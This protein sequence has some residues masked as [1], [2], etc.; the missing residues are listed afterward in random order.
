MNRHIW[1]VFTYE[2]RRNIRRK[3]FLFA[4]FGIPLIAFVIVFG[5]RVVS[6][7]NA[8]NQPAD[9]TDGVAVESDG[10]EFDGIQRA[11][12]VDLS[13]EFADP[14]ELGDILV[15][16]DDEAAANAAMLSGEI[17]G[18]YLIPA[19]YLE[20]GDVTLVIPRLSLNLVSSGPVE[21]LI[22]NHLARDVQDEDLFNRLLSPSD[23][24]E[25]NL[26]RDASGRTQTNFGT[27]FAV[28]YVFA[29]A[30]MMSVF[31]TNGY[32]MQT[33]IEEKETRLIEILVATMRPTQLLAGKILA[34]GLLGLVQILV[35][36]GSLFLIGR[37][38]A[39][40]AASPL[41]ALATI[42]LTA[43]KVIILLLY[44]VFG[45]LFFAAAYGMV[46]ALSTSMQEGPGYAVIFT[47]PAA[48]PFYFMTVFITTPDATLPVILSLIPVTAPLSMVMRVTLTT[49]PLWQIALSLTLLIITD[50][51]MIWLAGRMFRVQTLLAGQTPK[52]RDI[53]RL[54]RG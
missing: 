27:D 34:L 15:R 29:I 31:L 43:D 40:D 33:V 16:Y 21:Q 3:G 22:L 11:G 18:Y 37:L 44:F 8:Q 4:T 45:Y 54:L 7:L 36:V 52:L 20:T 49:V 17:D 2:L 6:Q 42:S 47:L 19:D 23:I 50:V 38:V 26:A 10:P 41:I 24:D 9:Q 25:V 1:Q 5:S 14:G 48:I 46:G 53:P 12:Y 13:G 28:I 39:G 35:W 51:V 32:L 30:L